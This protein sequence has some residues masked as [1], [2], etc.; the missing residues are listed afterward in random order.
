MNRYA[1][2]TKYNYERV[3]QTDFSYSEKFCPS[4]NII[5]GRYIYKTA[6]ELVSGEVCGVEKYEID[7]ATSQKFS[8]VSGIYLHVEGEEPDLVK[9]TLFGDDGQSFSSVCGMNQANHGV[10]FSTYE[11]NF[12]PKYLQIE[13]K[14]KNKFRACVKFC[15]V[16]NTLGEWGGQAKFYNTCGGTLKDD[17]E[18]LV[19]SVCGK[20]VLTFPEYPDSSDTVYNMLMP[21]RNTVLAIIGNSCGAKSAKLYF[22]THTDPDFSEDKCVCVNLQNRAAPT[23]YYFN[24]SSCEKCDGRLKSLRLEVEGDGELII[25]RYS[26]EQ[27]KRVFTPIANIESCT[28]DT[29]NNTISVCGNISGVSK[30][31]LRNSEVLLYET[32]MACESDGIDGKTPV[33]RGKVDESDG[34]WRFCVDNIPLKNGK[35][36]RLASQFVAFIKTSEGEIIPASERFYV[37]NYEA[38]DNNPYK[39]NVPDRCVSVCDFGACGDAYHNDTDAIQKALDYISGIGG[40]RVIV[41]GDESFYEKRYIVTNLLIHS[42]TEFVIQ[43]GAVL[44]Q[45]QIRRDYTYRVTYGHDGVVPGVNWTHNMHVSNLPLLQAENAENVKITGGGKLRGMDTGSEEGVDMHQRFSC[46]CPD[47]IHLIMIGFFGVKNIECRDIDIV[48]CNNYHTGFYHCE[49]LYATNMKFHEVKCLSGDGFGLMIGTHDVVINRCFFQSNDDYLVLV[50]VKRD[51]RGILWWT[52]IED[53]H[54]GPY[55]ITMRHCYI[56]ANT[57]GGVAFITWGTDAQRQE[58]A[59]IHNIRVYDNYFGGFKA[60][61][62]WFDNPY[63]GRVPFD[64]L[65][66]DDYSPVRDVRIYNNVYTD[67]VTMGCVHATDYISDCGLHSHSDFVNG[68]FSLG[69]LANWTANKNSNADSVKTIIFCDKEKGCIDRFDC[70]DVSLCQGLYLSGGKHKFECELSTGESGAELFVCKTANGETVKTQKYICKY[71][72]TADMEF[73]L[74]S[75]CDVY[76]GVRNCDRS[77]DGFAVI[78]KCKIKENG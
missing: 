67:F 74:D 34:V 53:E 59:E 42:N 23:S 75:D 7:D 43:K 35:I 73:V 5:E 31:A 40:G 39:F 57:G 14:S 77:R 50:S 58:D 61:G 46:G 48:R 18:K 45:S 25:Y 55:N 52:N 54:Y 16:L 66:T 62:G 27:E 36:S 68:D 64:N 29:Q 78:D 12:T 26:F 47:R 71:A 17:G 30:T 11:M 56:D 49:N 24:F 28:A 44:W 10:Y 2:K 60:I 4:Q 38:Y 51:P 33:G 1:V 20:T 69:G 15:H 32:N 65:E 8:C 19:L 22:N 37:D 6:D 70:G 3:R 13:S 63:R 76:V 21:R 72:H 9:V 41:P